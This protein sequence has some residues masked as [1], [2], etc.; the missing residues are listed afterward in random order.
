M[1]KS[2]IMTAPEVVDELAIH[3]GS[4]TVTALPARFHFGHEEK[5]AVDQ[6]FDESITSGN[7]PGYNGQQEE[8][9]CREFAAAIGT[10]YADAVN[11]GTNAVYVA[12]K[13][14]DLPP[15]S[16]V[17]VGSVTDP[18]GMMPVVINNCIPV[19]ADTEPG[20]FNTGAA[21]IEARITDRTSAIVLAHIGG[22]PAD[23]PA[24][25]KVANRHHLPVIED[26]AQSHLAT[27]Q[28]RNV[29]TFGRYG[30]FSLMFGKHMC[31][32]GQG[33]AVLSRT[34]N[35]YWSARRAA[36]R[37]KPFQLPAGSTNVMATLNCNMD[38]IHAAI[39]RAQLRK[40][41]S[42]VAR[43]RRVAA[44][45]REQG[46]G[47]LQSVTIPQL[48]PGFEHSYWWWRLRYNAE[49]MRCDK[50]E[51]CAALQAEGVLLIPHYGHAVP[52]NGAWYSER[53]RK[54][55]W[56]NPL[57]AGNPKAVYA[58]PNCERAIREHFI[59]QIFESYG[60]AEVAMLIA[61][62]RKVEKYYLR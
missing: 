33:G 61:A 47:D 15:F 43:R 42:I 19:P 20:S 34:E 45:L 27:I 37:G 10:E 14:L 32:G 17:I 44:M 7:A 38:E 21:E 60:E 26:C 24:I 12:L 18:G 62:F 53:H 30:A 59:L 9:F 58:V 1:S 56:N 13:A 6:L 48:R 36:D 39:G 28:G 46:L 22:E 57:Y 29:G 2:A 54:H 55:P 35:D 23:M 4:R 49:R 51:F 8:L 5:E 41:P 31:A 40:L 3:G 16:E 52:A 50:A 25:L 11:S